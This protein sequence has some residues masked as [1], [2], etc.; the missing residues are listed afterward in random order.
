MKD[1]EALRK[2]H[3][4]IRKERANNRY[5]QNPGDSNLKVTFG[6]VGNMHY[7]EFNKGSQDDFKPGDI[8]DNPSDSEEATKSQ[9]N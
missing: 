9:H 8:F 7:K 6:A 4:K 1:R 5:D 2:M 3:E